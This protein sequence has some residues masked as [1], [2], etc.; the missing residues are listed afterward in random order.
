MH[1]KKSE[2]LSFDCPWHFASGRIRLPSPPEGLSISEISRSLRDG[3][4]IQP[5]IFETSSERRLYFNRFSVQSVMNL[6][7]P[8]DL[9]IAYTKKMMS[10]LLFKPKPETIFMVGLGGGSLVKFC[11]KHLR[12]TRIIVAELDA[13]VIALRDEFYVPP[14]DERFR[15]VHGDGARL[16]SELQGTLDIILV[17]AFD[18]D[19]IAPTLAEYDFYTQAA[20]R[21]APDG[22]LI[23][24]LCGESSR[25][26]AHISRIRA[27]FAGSILLVPIEKDDNLL[28]FAFHSKI[29][30]SESTV[31][32][33]RAQQLTRMFPLDFPRFLDRIA[34][35][36]VL[37]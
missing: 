9:V 24:N 8:N 11:Y 20:A 13:N 3:A 4:L 2:I 10:F 19:G 30:L 36:K 5:Y 34:S 1:D 25:Y 27:A 35:G 12:R 15:V 22:V 33:T 23:M 17:D 32:A 6:N 16:I 7:R 14:D 29:N 18:P 21:L 37:Y 31:Y 26:E 28:L